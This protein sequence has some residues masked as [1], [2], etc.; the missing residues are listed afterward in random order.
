[1]RPLIVVVWVLTCLVRSSCEMSFS[2]WATRRAG[3]MEM[4]F[5]HRGADCKS[6]GDALCCSC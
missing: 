3:G 4:D 1:M 6:A 5:Y 2:Y